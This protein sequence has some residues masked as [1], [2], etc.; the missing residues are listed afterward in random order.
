MLTVRNANKFD[1]ENIPITDCMYG[2]AMDAHYTLK[3]F[4]VLE[5]KI[6]ELGLYDLC[7]NLLS[8]ANTVFLEPEFQGLNVSPQITR[9]VGKKL[10]TS[11]IDVHD[12]LFDYDEVSLKDNLSSN[13]DLKEVLYTREGGFELYPPDKTPKGAPSVSK[14]TLDIIL[15]QIN[16]ELI[17]RG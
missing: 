5:E 17:N 10:N 3:V 14:D 15:S 8:P 9:E 13:N 4:T 7:E 6:K 2:N 11:I 12:G 16:K 1:W